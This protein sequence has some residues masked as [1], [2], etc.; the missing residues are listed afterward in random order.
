MVQQLNH[1]NKKVVPAPPS[2]CPRVLRRK[3]GIDTRQEQQTPLP[4]HRRQA[5]AFHSPETIH[6]SKLELLRTRVA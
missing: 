6:A 3:N 4:N 5:G 2:S 1:P